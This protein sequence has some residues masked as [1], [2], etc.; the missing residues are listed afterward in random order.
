MQFIGQF[1]NFLAQPHARI[2]CDL[3]VAG[4]ACVQLRT[5]RHSLSQSGL[6]VHVHI[7]QLRPPYKLALGN[8][9]SNRFQSIH[10]RRHLSLF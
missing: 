5:S 10:N 4:P 1:A 6:D 8:L 2:Q 7:L 3:I 9:A